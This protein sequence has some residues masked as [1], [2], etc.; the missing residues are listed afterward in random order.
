MDFVAAIR[1]YADNF[2]TAL[3]FALLLV[4]VLP[5]G[6]I[7][8]SFISSG[9]VLLGYGFLNQPLLDSIILLL[10]ATVFLF[11]YSILICLMVLAV[12]R[13]VS[14]VKTNYYLSEK[15]HKFAV[16]YFKFL[17]VFTIICALLSSVLVELNVPIV[18]VNV[19]IFALSA[20]FLFL[21]QTIV[22]DEEG[23]GASILT[24][25]EFIAKN[26][27]SFVFLLLFGIFSV[28]VVVV[29]EFAVD[30]F[31]AFGSFISLLFSLVVLVPFLEVLKTMIYMKRFSI[32]ERYEN[33]ASH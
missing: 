24:N 18:L 21:P 14:S 3:A 11:F 9:T 28:F 15:I 2:S 31:F 5:F 6:A 27:P 26:V 16:K 22:V 30:Y 4:F 8:N 19:V 29:F 13:D 10:L 23:L 25:W 32:I 1:A 20:I 17:A 7:S 12:R 33:Q